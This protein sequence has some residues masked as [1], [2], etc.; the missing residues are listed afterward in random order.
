ML[1]GQRLEQRVHDRETAYARIDDADCGFAAHRG[2]LCTVRGGA[3][4]QVRTSDQTASRPAP[5]CAEN[6]STR[7]PPEAEATA[8]TA[9]P[10]AACASLSVFVTT[11][12]ATRPTCAR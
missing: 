7:S 6:G 5:V 10:A 3:S 8:A 9:R 1:G 12:A 4:S 2:A 11:T